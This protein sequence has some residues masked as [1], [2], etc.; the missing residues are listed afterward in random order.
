MGG[1]KLPPRAR[2]RAEDK[3]QKSDIRPDPGASV[4]SSRGIGHVLAHATKWQNGSQARRLCHIFSG[5]AHVLSHATKWQNGSQARRLCHIFGG[6]PNAG[7][8]PKK[9]K[10][11]SRFCRLTR[12]TKEVFVVVRGRLLRLSK[13]RLSCLSFKSK[14]AGSR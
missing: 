7:K 12:K 1:R 2:M 13:G 6:V 9:K 4:V 5:I 11:V 10:R 8:L 3:D 14:S